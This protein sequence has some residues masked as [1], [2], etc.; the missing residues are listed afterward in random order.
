MTPTLTTILANEK[1]FRL[2]QV[3]LAW[4]NPKL[5]S[6]SEMTTLS[7]DLR[8]R[9]EVVPWIAVKPMAIEV[10][11][12]DGTKKALLELS[13]NT[14]IE[15]VLMP[16]ADKSKKEAE[17][18]YTVCLST[19]VGC[20]MRC[21]FCTTGKL[22]F[23]KNLEAEEIVDQ[24]RFWQ[25]ELLKSDPEGQINNIVLMGQGEPLLNYDNV[26][27]AL[28]LFLNYTEIGPRKI[29]LSTV[30]VPLAMDRLLDDQDFPAVR[31]ALSLHTAIEESREKIILSHQKGFLEWLITWAN[32][33][34]RRFP[35]RTHFIGLEYTFLENVNDDDK[36]LKALIKLASKLGRV[37]INLIPYNTDPNNPGLFQGSKRE[38]IEIW[39]KA[40]L[41]KGF[42]STIRYSQGQDISAACG[43]LNNSHTTKNN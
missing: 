27:T 13:D 5:N 31:F 19:Q 14:T 32:K 25:K 4:F 37:R 7:K 20:P 11:P 12:A 29:T 38:T 34:H 22:G 43:Q 1:P 2:K 18:R 21:A 42:I 10:S 3:Y 17:H 39:Q 33:Y 24:F 6:Y 8:E 26:K 9:L 28:N 35:S 40:L 16:R 30:G 15:T 23:K 41:A 36:H